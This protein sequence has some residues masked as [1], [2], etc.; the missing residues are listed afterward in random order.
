MRRCG[1]RTRQDGE[2]RQPALESGRCRYHGGRSTGP[3]TLAAGGHYSK[4]LP[5]RLAARYGEALTDPELNSL[6]DD[7]AVLEARLCEL[8]QGLEA[9]EA[10]L[11]GPRSPR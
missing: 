3:H 10:R 1:A 2:C 6:R 9:D 5:R 7:Q 11:S 4:Y 8:L